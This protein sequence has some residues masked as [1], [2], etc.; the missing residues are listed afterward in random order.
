MNSEDVTAYPLTWPQGWPRCFNRKA[1]QFS[2][3]ITIARGVEKIRYELGLLGADNII[4]STNKKLK[5]NG[6]PF[7]DGEYNL[8]DPGA[9]VYFVYKNRGSCLAA[10][11]YFRLS[12]NLYAIGKTIECLRSIER[13]GSSDMLERAFTGFAGLP[14]PK[15]KRHWSQVFNVVN[16]YDSKIED[17]ASYV[18][19]CYRELVKTYHPDIGGNVELFHELQLALF[20]Y[21]QELSNSTKIS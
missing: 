19:N 14:A 20:E 5:L 2:G 1:A 17:R 9:V 8:D 11:K 3:A 13:W 18:R 21:N 7:S 16:L 15:N 6:L 4:I 12:H 10:D